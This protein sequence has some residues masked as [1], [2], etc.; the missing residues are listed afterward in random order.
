LGEGEDEMSVATDDT[1]LGSFTATLERRVERWLAT[2]EAGTVACSHLY[3][4]L[5]PLFLLLA[6]VS[7]DP[8]VDARERTAIRSALKYIVAPFD[9]IPEGVVGTSGYRDDLVLAAYVVERLEAIV[10]APE[11]RARWH[12]PGDPVEVARA[13]LD[14]AAAMIGPDVCERLSAW[15]AA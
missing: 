13:I 9:F 15:L 10:G 5:P 6:E 12:G 1:E 2:E 11:L 4:Y 8:A 14:A 7:L 3:R